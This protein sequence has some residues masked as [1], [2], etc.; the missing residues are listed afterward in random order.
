MKHAAT[1][2]ERT[3]THI[4]VR[5]PQKGFLRPCWSTGTQIFCGMCMR[6][7]V[8]AT[9]GASCPIC[10]SVVERILEVEPVRAKEVAPR[11][12]E[13]RQKPKPADSTVVLDIQDSRGVGA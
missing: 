8:E 13:A 1:P 7:A 12:C 10:A 9:L 3:L 11:E 6:G 5:D 2:Q 4:Y